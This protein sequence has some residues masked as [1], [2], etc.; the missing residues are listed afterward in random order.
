M[1]HTYFSR[2]FSVALFDILFGRILI[3]TCVLPRKAEIICLFYARV[4]IA[5]ICSF[6]FFFLLS[7][8]VSEHVKEMY[9]TKT[10]VYDE[11]RE[12]IRR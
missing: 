4:L 8:F 6:C 12:Q 2:V 3:L 10:A 1:K 7:A 11:M 9:K 5:T